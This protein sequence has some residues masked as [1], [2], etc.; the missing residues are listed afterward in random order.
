MASLNPSRRE[1]IC[2]LAGQISCQSLQLRDIVDNIYQRGQ[3]PSRPP[4]RPPLGRPEQSTGIRGD[5]VGVR[6][7][8]WRRP[9]GLG[10][11]SSEQ[12]LL[13]ER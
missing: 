2:R 11:S 6:R 1:E 10:R 9:K 8:G 7:Q 3:S 12:G 5:T 4:S 13:R